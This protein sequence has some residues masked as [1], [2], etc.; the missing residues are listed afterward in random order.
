VR[1]A[2]S[3]AAVAEL[4]LMLRCNATKGVVEKRFE[5]DAEV[6]HVSRRF[7][8]RSALIRT[9]RLQL[10]RMGLTEVPSELFRMKN[11]KQL[12][13]SINKLCSLPSEIAQLP[14]LEELWVRPSTRSGAI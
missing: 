8:R 6:V 11:V 4:E 12:F 2:V 13:L 3:F 10:A 9:R 7:A 14:A 1:R 5:H